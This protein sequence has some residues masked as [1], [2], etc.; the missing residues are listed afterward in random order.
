MLRSS[1]AG[2]PPQACHGRVFLS[3]PTP[4]TDQRQPTPFATTIFNHRRPGALLPH[5]RLPPLGV[6]N[7]LQQQQQRLRQLRCL[8]YSLAPLVAPHRSVGFVLIRPGIRVVCACACV[9]SFL[10]VSV[11]LSIARCGLPRR[12]PGRIRRVADPDSCELPQVCVSTG[13]G[14]GGAPVSA[15]VPIADPRTTRPKWHPQ[16]FH[17]AC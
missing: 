10:T 12:R 8:I 15:A 6:Q 11:F 5:L 3:Q 2:C 17:A 4:F 7:D 14:P 1:P 16:A 9:S 13:C